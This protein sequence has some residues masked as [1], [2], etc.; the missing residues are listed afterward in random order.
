VQGVVEPRFADLDRGRHLAVRTCRHAG[1]VSRLQARVEYRQSRR[2]PCPLVHFRT[3]RF[4]AEAPVAL[5]L[6]IYARAR[7]PRGPDS[8]YFV[9][10]G[11]LQER[12]ELV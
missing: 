2:R 1:L 6:G 12:S 4:S 8:V 11:T 5:T 7:H 3:F 10:S 9:R